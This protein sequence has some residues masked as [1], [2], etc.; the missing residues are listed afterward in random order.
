MP[1]TQTINSLEEL[2]FA[3]EK[4]HDILSYFIIGIPFDRVW[5]NYKYLD[6]S[7]YVKILPIY[8]Y[9]ESYDGSVND[10]NY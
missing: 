2:F 9:D 7:N 10:N 3:Y 4:K 8:T 1:I 6:R 5:K